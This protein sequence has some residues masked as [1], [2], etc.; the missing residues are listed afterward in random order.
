MTMP[1]WVTLM[2]MEISDDKN[3]VIIFQMECL[4][5]KC[6]YKRIV[7]EDVVFHCNENSVHALYC[8]CNLLNEKADQSLFVGNDTKIFAY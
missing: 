1:T 2:C 4:S 8:M 3:I 5:V 6:L 7:D